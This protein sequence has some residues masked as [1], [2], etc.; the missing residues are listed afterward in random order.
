M[1]HSLSIRKDRKVSPSRDLLQI[2]SLL[3]LATRT[4]ETSNQETCNNNNADDF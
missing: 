1:T 4:Q 3:A 2:G